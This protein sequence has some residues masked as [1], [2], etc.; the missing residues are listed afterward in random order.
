MFGLGFFE[1]IALA[2][3]ALVFVGPARLP[4]MMRQGGK[5]FVQLRRTANDV[6][7]TFDGV[8]REAEDEMRKVEREKFV[9]LFEQNNQL[10]EANA[11]A[12]ATGTA[13]AQPEPT[14]DY[15]ELN[16]HPPHPSSITEDTVAATAPHDAPRAHG[17]DE[18]SQSP[19]QNSNQPKNTAGE[20]TQASPQTSVDKN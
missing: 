4:E 18:G 6:K 1:M 16:P 8:I 5:L 2:V 17:F 20:Q 3:I 7:S 11:G 9:K 10:P 15:P 12:P 14:P 19:N 13:A